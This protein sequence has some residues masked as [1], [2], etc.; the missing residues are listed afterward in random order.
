MVNQAGVIPVIFAS[1]LTAIPA[2]LITQLISQGQRCRASACRTNSRRHVPVRPEQ[3]GLGHRHLPASSSHL[4]QP[5]P[6]RRDEEVRRPFWNSAGPS[7]RP[8]RKA[9]RITLA[10]SDLPGVIAVPCSTRSDR[11]RK[12][13]RTLPGVR[14]ADRDRC[15]LMV[16]Q[17]RVAHAAQTGDGSREA[18][19]RPGGQGTGGEGPSSSG[20][21]DFRTGESPSKHEKY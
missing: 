9:E 8:S 19:N 12:T 3:P 2:P 11:R 15:R 13:C 5:D 16:K 21:A 10:G 1:S 4:R 18:F 20:S 14:G 17:T 7:T 6:C